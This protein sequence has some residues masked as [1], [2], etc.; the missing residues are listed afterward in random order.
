MT[1]RS[2]LANPTHKAETLAPATPPHQQHS[3]PSGLGFYITRSDNAMEQQTGSTASQEDIRKQADQAMAI[4]FDSD[5]TATQDDVDQ[6]TEAILPYSLSEEHF[7]VI[8]YLYRR[9]FPWWIITDRYNKLVGPSSATVTEAELKERW[10]YQAASLGELEPGESKWNMSPE[11][12]TFILHQEAKNTG[13]KNITMAVNERFGFNFQ[14]AELKA[15]YE[16]Q[17]KVWGYSEEE[18]EMVMD[19]IRADQR[20]QQSPWLQ[21]EDRMVEKQWVPGERDIGKDGGTE[22]LIG[23]LSNLT[24][25]ER[26]ESQYAQPRLADD[27]PAKDLANDQDMADYSDGKSDLSSSIQSV[28]SDSER[29]EQVQAAKQGEPKEAK[30]EKIE[31]TKKQEDLEEDGFKFD[32]DDCIAISEKEL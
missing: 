20:R 31:A 16:E 29:F 6:E 30:K 11:Q 24:V 12:L 4:A 1:E 26:E 32:D 14:E 18:K 27:A 19:M 7:H 9:T 3:Q 5:W 8:L 21:D 2:F 23:Q 22:E 10:L 25:E 28:F 17:T 15:E 13:W